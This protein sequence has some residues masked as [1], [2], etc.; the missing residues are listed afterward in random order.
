MERSLSAEMDDNIYERTSKKRKNKSRSTEEPSPLNFSAVDCYAA[1]DVIRQ[2][3]PCYLDLKQTMVT[4]QP[5]ECLYLPS[6]W[7]HEVTSM[8]GDPTQKSTMVTGCAGTGHLA[9]NYWFYPPDSGN[10][11]KPYKSDFWPQDWQE[12]GHIKTNK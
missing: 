10:F 6:G 7:F 12:R 4:L 1:P 8:S 9:F 2:H 5:G 11:E 3:T